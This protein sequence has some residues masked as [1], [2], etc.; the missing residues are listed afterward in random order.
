MR[1]LLPALL[2]LCACAGPL[3]DAHF[4]QPRAGRVFGE[5][6]A[7]VYSPDYRIRYFGWERLHPFDVFKYD[8]IARALV[9]E[10]RAVTDDFFVPSPADRATLERFHDPDYLDSLTDARVLRRALETPPLVAAPRALD[11][12]MLRPMRLQVGGTL[13][14]AHLAREHGLA[15]NLGGGAH[16]A[17]PDRGHGF[18]VY[19]DVAVAIAQ[20]RADGFDGR[21]LI[22]DTDAHQGD[23]NQAAFAFDETVFA[24]SFQQEGIFPPREMG[25]FD[26]DFEANVGGIYFNEIVGHILAEVLEDEQPALV[27][28]VAGADVLADD[29][30]ADFRLDVD[31]LV[32][33]DL[34]VAEAVRGR[35]IPLVHVLAG[36]YGPSA[37]WA[38]TE[39][40]LALL[41]AFGAGP[42][43][44]SPSPRLEEPDP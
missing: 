6:V 35:G 4:E 30:L 28:H 22:V 38:Q 8:K 40:V 27:F 13:L 31:H 29:P 23:G 15:I 20:L 21:V 24:L 9:D 36:G 42:A 37:A 7:I 3:H 16:H 25:D 18:C 26:F 43:P 17:H 41:D 12:M 11:R 44:A 5:Q 1:W 10:R 14:A 33:R 39:S 34:M 32:A 19:N 2:L